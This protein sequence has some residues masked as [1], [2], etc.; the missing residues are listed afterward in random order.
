MQLPVMPPVKPMLAKPVAGGVPLPDSVAGGLVYEP[1][2]DGFRCIVFRDGDEIA[3]ASRN[4][5]PF[6]RYFPELIEPLRASLPDACVID[7]EIVIA[8]A[9]GDDSHFA[10]V[11]RRTHE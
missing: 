2:W 7:G 3:L 10:T 4:E 11:P 9:D 6:T 8:S 5:K 1:K